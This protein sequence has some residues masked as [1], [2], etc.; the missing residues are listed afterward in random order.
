MTNSSGVKLL[1]NGP[2]S[3]L[4]EA[5]SLSLWHQVGDI[6][7]ASWG[8]KDNGKSLDGPGPLTRAALHRAITKVRLNYYPGNYG[9]RL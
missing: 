4:Q 9:G 3:D 2:V 6:A 5:L 1:G 7:S 8:P